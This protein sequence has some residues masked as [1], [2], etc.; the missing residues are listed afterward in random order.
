MT[1]P[2]PN[3][4]ATGDLLIGPPC[5]PHDPFHRAVILL[6]SHDQ[7]GSSGL[8]INRPTNLTINSLIGDNMEDHVIYYGGPVGLD[9]LTFI[10][11]SKGNIQ[12]SM[13]VIDDI[14]YAGNMD[15]MINTLQKQAIMPNQIRFCLGYSGWEPGQLEQELQQDYWFI[16]RVNADIIFENDT[17]TLWKSL[18]QEMGGPYATIANYP[19]HPSLN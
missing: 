19:H 10:H 2:N 14:F 9:H 8:I 7:E 4:V 11:R 3:C 16:T 1:D 18:L 13:K 12:E 5:R 17:R 6:C 15:D